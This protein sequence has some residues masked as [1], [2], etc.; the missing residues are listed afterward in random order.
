[1]GEGWDG[2][3]GTGGAGVGVGVKRSGEWILSSLK[4]RKRKKEEKRKK[5]WKKKK[6]TATMH[7]IESV[8]LSAEK[9]YSRKNF[10]FNYTPVQIYLAKN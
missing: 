9:F 10:P 7:K 8:F 2:A 6:K 4:K 3:G 5:K 1:M